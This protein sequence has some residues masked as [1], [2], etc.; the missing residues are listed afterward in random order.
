MTSHRTAPR[1]TVT[2]LAGALSLIAVVSGCGK[3]GDAAQN[4]P[5]QLTVLS[6]YLKGTPGGKL[7]YDE[8]A[9]FTDE[10]GIK[11][12]IVEAGEDLDESYETSLAAGKEADVVF[13][14]VYDKTLGW[15]KNGAAVPVDQYLDAWGLRAKVEPQALKEWTDADGKVMGFPFAAFS[16]PV[17]YNTDLLERAGVGKIPA[18]TDELIDAADKLRDAGI[19]PMAVGGNDWSGQKLFAQIAQSYSTPEETEQLYTQGGFCA[20]DK[21]MRGIGLFITLRDA[22]VFIDKAQGFTFDAMQST[23]FTGKAAMM[24]QGSWAFSEVP[25]KIRQNTELAG[26]PL[27]SGAAFTKPTSYLGYTST[28]FW[29]SPNGDKKRDAVKEF[30]SYF[31]Q[32]DVSGKFLADASIYPA[33]SLDAAHRKSDDPLL[34]SA[35]NDVPK[36]S[37]NALLP[38]LYVPAA[39]NTPLVQATGLAFGK[40]NGAKKIC[41]A[42]DQAYSGVQ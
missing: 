34:N 19:E 33:L 32:P 15:T 36:R 42:L 16:W 9:A 11:V 5:R 8:A 38:D 29:I 6:Q 3:G 31:Y 26:L 30:V 23:Y 28:G 40:G 24:S 22:G 4:D 25:E 41:A 35:V 2:A 20:S 17:W 12:K 1:R 13:V 27:P 7:F 39:A 37:V 21:A 18:T 14:N 10:T